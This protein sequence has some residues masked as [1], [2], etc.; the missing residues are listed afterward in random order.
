MAVTCQILF[1]K[2]QYSLSR[3]FSLGWRAIKYFKMWNLEVR[4]GFEFCSFTYKIHD[5]GGSSLIS[6]CLEFLI[7]KVD[8]MKST[9]FTR[10]CERIPW[11]KACEHSALSPRHTQGK[12]VMCLGRV[13]DGYCFFF[14]LIFILFFFSFIFISWRLITLQYCSGFC[15]TLT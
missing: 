14:L 3:L 11:N 4:S 8:K 1:H 2:L 13:S 5:F 7:C 12:L 15:H 6:P 9:K 10:V